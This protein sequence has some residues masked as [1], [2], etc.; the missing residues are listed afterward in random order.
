MCFG[1]HT[2]RGGWT[3]QWT[4]VAIVIDRGTQDVSGQPGAGHF[5]LDVR[6]AD[7]DLI[8]LTMGAGGDP[9]TSVTYTAIPSS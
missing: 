6:T 7:V 4:P 8:A 3:W 9:L 5:D 1:V 2:R